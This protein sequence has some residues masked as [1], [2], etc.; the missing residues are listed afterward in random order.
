MLD[1][2]KL[3]LPQEIEY[4]QDG[5][6]TLRK[7]ELHTGGYIENSICSLQLTFEGG[8][9]YIDYYSEDDDHLSSILGIDEPHIAMGDLSLESF[10]K[11]QERAL[12]VLIVFIDESQKEMLEFFND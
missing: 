8:C 3:F 10:Q 4:K 5:K 7:P 11:I 9:V 2:G 1:L 6:L 12:Q